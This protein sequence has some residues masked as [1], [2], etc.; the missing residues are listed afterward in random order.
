MRQT[1]SLLVVEIQTY[2]FLH[3][4][5]LFLT[6]VDIVIYVYCVIVAANEREGRSGLV[7]VCGCTNANSYFHR[8]ENKV[9]FIWNFKN[10]IHD[11]HLEVCNDI[12]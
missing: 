8:I 1:G 9:F 3:S 10:L 5:I 11:H 4:R 12:P 6:S 7:G 2:W